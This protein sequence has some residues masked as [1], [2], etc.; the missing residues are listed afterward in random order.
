MPTEKHAKYQGEDLVQLSVSE[1]KHVLRSFG[2]K[3]K[4]RKSALVSVFG[5]GWCDVSTFHGTPFSL[6]S[7]RSDG[8]MIVVIVTVFAWIYI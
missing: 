5:V 6:L 2:R 7:I 3:T 8:S 4:G 1:L